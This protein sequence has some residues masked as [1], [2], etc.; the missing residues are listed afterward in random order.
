MSNTLRRKPMIDLEWK[1]GLV[2]GLD[3]EQVVF[4]EEGEEFDQDSETR[5]AINLYL[6]LAVIT[7]IL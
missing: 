2:F 4:I 3:T 5:T 1:C 7:L 6:G